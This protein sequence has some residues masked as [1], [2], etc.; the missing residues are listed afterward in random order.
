MT[1]QNFR[2]AFSEFQ[3]N[4]K[5]KHIRGVLRLWDLNH[6]HNSATRLSQLRS[7]NI[8]WHGGVLALMIVLLVGSITSRSFD[9]SDS[10]TWYCFL[11]L[12]TFYL[13]NELGQSAKNELL[14]SLVDSQVRRLFF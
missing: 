11:M 2:L 13:W 7:K 4:L 14:R 8:S 10:Y 9:S 3:R 12:A 6:V 1:R 5:K